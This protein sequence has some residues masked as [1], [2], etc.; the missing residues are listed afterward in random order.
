MY[1]SKVVSLLRLNFVFVLFISFLFIQGCGKKNNSTNDKNDSNT[2][3]KTLSKDENISLDKPFHVVFD[4]SGMSKGTVD[5]YYSGKKARSSSSMEI[6]GQKM[7]ATAYFDGDSKMMYLV[8]D[9]AGMK[10]G[11][12]MAINSA[13]DQKNNNGE[14]IDITNFRDKLKEMDK[15]GSEEVIGRQCDI[16][17]TKDGKTTISVFKETIPLKFSTSDGKT[18]LVANKLETDVKVTDDMFIP[19]A[20]IQYQDATDMMKGMKNMKSYEDKSK[21]M[22]DVMKKYKK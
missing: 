9:I 4:I 11:M 20:D 10:R 6:S 1:K 13:V 18:V 3:N 2:E 8:N 16:Y 5:A 21:E 12:K 22:D 14:Q 7:N 19:P 17:K 15:I